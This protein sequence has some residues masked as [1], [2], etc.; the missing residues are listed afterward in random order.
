MLKVEPPYAFW[1]PPSSFLLQVIGIFLN[2]DI[3]EYLLPNFLLRHQD[4][5]GIPI[6][7]AYWRQSV[8]WVLV[9]VQRCPLLYIWT[10]PWRSAMPGWLSWDCPVD[11]LSQSPWPAPTAWHRSS[12]QVSWPSSCRDVAG[13]SCSSIPGGTSPSRDTLTPQTFSS[14]WQ[15]LQCLDPDCRIRPLMKV[16]RECQRILF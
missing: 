15:I 8:S 11:T 3:D 5:R 14:S 16:P 1:I 13:L 10:W 9:L 2:A 6:T 7:E 4:N 12:G